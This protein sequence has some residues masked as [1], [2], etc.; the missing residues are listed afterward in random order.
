MNS[1]YVYLWCLFAAAPAAAR[2]IVQFLDDTGMSGDDFDLIATGDLGYTGSTLLHQIL[3]IDYNVD[4]KAVH[5]DCGLMIFDRDAQDVH[6]G[7]SGCGCG[8]SV[9]CSHIVKRL[10]Q[11][12]FHRVLFVA[13]GALMSP[14]ST[15]QGHP[16]PAIAHAVMLEK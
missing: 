12:V 11:G 7:G 5:N 4:I 10:K 8:A 14:T 15:K 2:T 16:I 6:S 9:L 3:S 1:K 13:T